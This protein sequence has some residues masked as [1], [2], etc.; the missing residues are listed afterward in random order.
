MRDF[1]ETLGL[2]EFFTFSGDGSPRVP[3]LFRQLPFPLPLFPLCPS[4][5]CRTACNA[6]KDM[7]NPLFFFEARFVELLSILALPPR[8]LISEKP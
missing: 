1:L 7:H 8:T 4:F 6:P 2:D 3:V 5:T